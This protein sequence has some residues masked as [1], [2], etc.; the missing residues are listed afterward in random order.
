MQT[1]GGTKE[2]FVKLSLPIKG[3]SKKSSSNNNSH[4]GGA[5]TMRECPDNRVG[6]LVLVGS[7]FRVWRGRV[8]GV[9]WNWSREREGCPNRLKAEYDGAKMVRD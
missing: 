9:R 8:R 3:K 7:D 5:V 4:H 1:K 2:A 6:I